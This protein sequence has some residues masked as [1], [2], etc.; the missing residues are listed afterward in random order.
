MRQMKVLYIIQCVKKKY[1]N[2]LSFDIFYV[3]AKDISIF[4]DDRPNAKKIIFLTLYRDI[5]YITL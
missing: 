1:K 2:D 5:I 4:L 3:L